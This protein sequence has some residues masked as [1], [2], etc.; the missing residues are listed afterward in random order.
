MKGKIIDE[1]T[2][3]QFDGNAVSKKYTSI[4][5]IT[6][7]FTDISYFNELVHLHEN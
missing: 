2:S 1:D 5:P 3:S 6:F 4:T 7:K